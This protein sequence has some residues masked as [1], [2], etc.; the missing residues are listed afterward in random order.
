MQL[1]I[2]HRIH[3]CRQPPYEDPLPDTYTPTPYTYPLHLLL[4]TPARLPSTQIL[5]LTFTLNSQVIVPYRLSLRKP[6]ASSTQLSGACMQALIMALA[7][8]FG[9]SLIQ[10]LLDYKADVNHADQ[11]VR[12]AV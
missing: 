6:R 4:A 12:C 8:G 9:K 11:K 10:L 3:G 2:P 5:S 1:A 7:R